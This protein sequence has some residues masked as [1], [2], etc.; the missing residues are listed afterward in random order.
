M[1]AN[2]ASPGLTYERALYAQGVEPIAG[3]DEAG[4]GALA[5]PVVSAAVVLPMDRS[6]LQERLCDVRDSK[7]LDAR[8]RERCFQSITQ[9]AVA[10]AIG[11]ASNHE[12]DQLGL[13]PATR[14]SMRRA[15]TALDSEAHYLLLDYMI[16]P[17]EER[18]QTS[19]TKGDSISLSIAAASIV[20]KVSRDLEMIRWDEQ[21]PGYG[22]S[23]HKGYGTSEHR[24]ALDR[25]GPS[26]LHRRSYA[27]VAKV[28]DKAHEWAD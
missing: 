28:C 5:G 14:L 7:E 10:W 18:P 21:I 4:R 15:L 19:L 22:F 24:L 6:D 3:I 13:I 1:T 12:V 2:I 27:P 23:R 26:R 11:S 17:E 25:L 16:L 8:Q 20:A 9:V